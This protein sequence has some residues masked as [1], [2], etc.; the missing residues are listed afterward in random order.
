[1][2]PAR[3][4][5]IALVFM[6]AATACGAGASRERAAG[7][8]GTTLVAINAA[9]DSFAAWDREHQQGIVDDA[10]TGPEAES[11]VRAYR[12]RRVKVAQAFLG[13]YA[14]LVVA[15]AALAATGDDAQL[16]ERLEQA[17]T[18]AVA[19]RG[20]LDELRGP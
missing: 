11:R 7:A 12:V 16:G 20:A 1:M 2:T 8:L 3:S 15:N 18:A 19:L 9:R 14:A 17:F 10:V 13:A 5:V 6:L 4:T